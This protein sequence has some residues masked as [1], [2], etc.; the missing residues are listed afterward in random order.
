[1]FFAVNFVE[2]I[3]DFPN[4]SVIDSKGVTA[5]CLCLGVQS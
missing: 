2:E 4:G 5:P 1:M 3:P